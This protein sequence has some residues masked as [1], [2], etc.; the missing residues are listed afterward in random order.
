MIKRPIGG[1]WIVLE[2]QLFGSSLPAHPKQ[3]RAPTLDSPAHASSS[4]CAI[5]VVRMQEEGSQGSVSWE[6]C[7]AS[8]SPD[9]R[10]LS[11]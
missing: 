11:W 8:S 10:D 9:Q 1:I 6:M 2:R 4:V 5:P 3:H 7:A